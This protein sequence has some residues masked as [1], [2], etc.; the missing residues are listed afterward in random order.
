M[1]KKYA[2]NATLFA[3]TLIS[4]IYSFSSI[5][6]RFDHNEHMYVTSAILI[7]QGMELYQDFA[8]LQMPNISYIYAYIFKFLNI[9]EYFFLVAKAIAL[10]LYLAC[11]LCIYKISR[12][13]RNDYIVSWAIALL[14]LTNFTLLRSASEASNYIAPLLTTLL[15]VI[16]FIFFLEGNSKTKNVNLLLSAMFAGLSIG[17]KLTYLTIL[18]PFYLAA[19]MFYFSNSQRKDYIGFLIFNLYLSCGLIIGLIPVILSYTDF[20]VFYFNNY[21]YH[22]L[23]TQ[24]RELTNYTGYMNFADK[25]GFSIK[26]LNRFDN[27]LLIFSI[28]TLIITRFIKS[29]KKAKT[30]KQDSLIGVT[31]SLLLISGFLSAIAPT[32]SFIQYYS[33]PIGIAFLLLLFF[34][35][36]TNH[37]NL[38]KI[39]GFAILLFCLSVVHNFHNIQKYTDKLSDRSGWSAIWVHDESYKIRD[40]YIDMYGEQEISVATLSPLFALESG[41]DIYREFSTGPFLYRVGD[42]LSDEKLLKFNGSSETKVYQFLEKNKPEIIITGFEKHLDNEF[43]QYALDHSYLEIPSASKQLRVFFRAS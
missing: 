37:F 15:S 8:F 26:T 11:S 23:N 35:S 22:A 21:G 4:L 28:S 13:L 33:M 42:F 10:I 36:I 1:T 5:M 7:N 24:W 43:N 38:Y 12:L 3:F 32:P 9:E 6:A 25:L 31:W 40:K 27:L 34:N 14:F 19:S 17:F 18:L 2:L 16:C 39:R 29:E 30:S 20:D 41:M